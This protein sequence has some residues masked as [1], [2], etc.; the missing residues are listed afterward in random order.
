MPTVKRF[1]ISAEEDWI[2]RRAGDGNRVSFPE[3]IERLHSQPG[4]NR[5]V[6]GG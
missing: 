4:M 6:F 5:C 3:M 2:H 1:R